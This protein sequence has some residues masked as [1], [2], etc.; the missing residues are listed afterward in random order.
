ML[1]RQGGEID[2]GYIA[3]FAELVGENHSKGLKF[4]I[5]V[6]GGKT[7]SEYAR[8]V[9]AL[10][11]NEFLADRVGIS[12]TRLNA[13]L[14][15]AAMEGIAYPRVLT[16]F[17]NAVDA[18][19]EGLT[20]VMGGMLEG[21]TTDT[22]AVLLAERIGAKTLLNLSNVEAVFDS[23]PKVNPKAKKYSSMSHA[24]LVE[25]ASRSDD[26]RART[27]FVFDLIACKLAARSGIAVHFIHGRKL[28]EVQKAI[29]GKGHSGTVVRS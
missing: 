25:L 15:I 20:P 17:D 21:I 27:H 19:R 9:R 2:D 8:A 13:Q 18:L 12:V 28:D 24:Q 16:D 14:L 23:D 11:D 1:F 10:A 4:A 5:L 26:R 29:D 22:D 3:D 7:N 6:G